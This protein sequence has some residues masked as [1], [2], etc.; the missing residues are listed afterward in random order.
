MNETLSVLR[1]FCS[2]ILSGDVEAYADP[3]IRSKLYPHLDVNKMIFLLDKITD[4]GLFQSMPKGLPP[5][6]RKNVDALISKL[7]KK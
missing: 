3:T 4:L 7:K 1:Q 2:L 5:L 6:K